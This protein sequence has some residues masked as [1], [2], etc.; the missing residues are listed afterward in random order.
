MVQRPRGEAKEE[1]GENGGK[2]ERTQ[3]SIP[4]LLAGEACSD[5]KEETEARRGEARRGSFWNGDGTHWRGEAREL[6]RKNK[7][8]GYGLGEALCFQGEGEMR[9]EGFGLMRG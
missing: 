3:Q 6:Q 4:I 7:G 8:F 2:M 9:T 1:K 5:L